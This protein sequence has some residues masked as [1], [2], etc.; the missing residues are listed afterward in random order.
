MKDAQGKLPE[1]K[2]KRK[3]KMR[4]EEVNFS[5]MAQVLS[6]DEPSTFEEAS[7]EQKWNAENQEVQKN[8]TW[9]LVELHA[10][11]QAIGCRWVYRTKYKADGS[12][13]KHKAKLVAKG[14]KQHEGIDYKET[15]AP[16]VKMNT[17]RI[18]LAIFA[19]LN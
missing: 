15:F 6:V 9:D 10:G 2:G 18:I 3:S 17:I 5:L 4:S 11:K 8:R 12:I 16:V 1:T 19:Q 14:Y 7:K 13:D